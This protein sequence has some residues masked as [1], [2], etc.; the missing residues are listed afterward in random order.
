MIKII[1]ILV[2]LILFFF[3]E[4]LFTKNKLQNNNEHGSARF[5]TKKEIANYFKAVNLYNIEKPGYPISFSS[6]LKTIY[7]DYET[8][9]WCFLGSTG[10]GKTVTAMIPECTFIANAKEKRSVCIT[11]PKGEIFQKTSEMFL[12]NGY[13]V[14][15]IDFRNP[16]LSNHINILDPIINE[17]DKYI[18]YKNTDINK[19]NHHLSEAN[20]LI[21]SI[22][23]MV[24]SKTG[25]EK[26]PFWNNSAKNLLAG[27]ISFFLE[28]YEIGKI[29]KE[30][31]TMTC[32]KKF[33]NSIM[34]EENLRQFKSIIDKKEYGLK[35]KDYLLSILSA[36]ENTYKSIISVFSEK[37][38]IFDDI[39]VEYITSSSDF[40][41]NDFGKKASVLYLI[42]PD[43]DK[44]YYS[45][46][47]I[48]VGLLYKELVKE[49]NLN[50]NKCLDVKIEWLLD[51][52][53]NCPPFSDIES[54]VSVGRSR[55]MRFYF[56]IQ[57]FSQLNNVYGKDVAKIILD[58]CGLVYL[59][60]N[61][62]ETAEEVSKRLGNQTIESKSIS[63]SINETKKSG[64]KS[65]SLIARELLTA[66]EIKRLYHKTIIFPIIG[67]PILRDT[68]IYN[69]FNIYKSGMIKRC[70]KDII[71]TNNY[72]TI[73]KYNMSRLPSIEN[74]SPY[75][76]NDS[77]L[78][79]T[80]FQG[81]K[82]IL[83]NKAISYKRE[84]EN[85]RMFLSIKLSKINKSTILKLNGYLK[86]KPFISVVENNIIKIHIKNI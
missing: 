76:E 53:A 31:I 44:T 23:S 79:D 64:N 47:T 83:K 65:L 75:I 39:N 61:T 72:F 36:S 14:Y 81:I 15:T 49:A 52:F 48:I 12:D 62:E 43:E 42:I 20:R 33:Q 56:F 66:D 63:Q 7:F 67:H 2:F 84:I 78:L 50:D 30:Q 69:K 1:I 22:S 57:S 37:M 55:G 68:I 25:N 86:N 21:V 38:S 60:T 5:S 59:K 13:N 51:E 6:D 3:L 73:E 41:F 18:K 71:I 26:D 85:E 80:I 28:E 46:V 45:L 9:H 10:S 58:N 17:Y 35:S 32:I 16:E 34:P 4:P 74:D 82:D 70:V 24:I 8:P 27:L 40:V 29:K 54:M 19:S 11:D 77:A